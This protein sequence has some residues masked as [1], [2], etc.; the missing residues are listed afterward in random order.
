MLHWLD[1]NKKIEQVA[2]YRFQVE[3]PGAAQAICGKIRELPSNQLS[4]PLQKGIAASQCAKASTKISQTFHKHS[5]GG[6]SFKYDWPDLEKVNPAVANQVW[7]LAQKYGYKRKPPPTA[8][9]KK[10]KKVVHHPNVLS[11]PG[12]ITTN[13]LMPMAF[14][15]WPE[16]AFDGNPRTYYSG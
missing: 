8:H 14:K 13:N 9:T 6:K 4:A 12:V 1:W 10:K 2:D 7:E 3:D 5:A 11:C 15:H 16:H